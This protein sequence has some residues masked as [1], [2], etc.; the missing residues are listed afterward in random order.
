MATQFKNRGKKREKNEQQ[1]FTIDSDTFLKN[2]END[3]E[4][5]RNQ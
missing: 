4:K 2:M 1:Q 3:R 5:S